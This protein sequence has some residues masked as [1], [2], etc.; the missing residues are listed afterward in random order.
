MSAQDGAGREHAAGAAGT[1][2]AAVTRC[3]VQTRPQN[4][5]VA[6][7]VQEGSDNHLPCRVVC[8]VSEVTTY[9]ITFHMPRGTVLSEKGRK[10]GP[11]LQVPLR[12]L[13]P[14]Q[15]SVAGSNTYRNTRPL[16]PPSPST[17]HAPQTGQIH[18]KVAVC[19]PRRH[20]V[21][22]PGWGGRGPGRARALGL[23]QGKV[24]E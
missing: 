3:Y 13:R 1:V 17:A 8:E 18:P 4:R 7:R 21:M 24:V 12:P 5:A 19:R 6:G 22:E 14:K 15:H 20:A 16:T 2:D 9:T 23:T 10:W 11:H